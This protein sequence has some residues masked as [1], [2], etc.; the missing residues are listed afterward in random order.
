MDFYDLVRRR[1][2]CRAYRSEPVDEAALG[3][4][5]EAGRLAPTAANR[6]PFRVLVIPTGPR[7]DA[8]ARIYGRAWFGQA[9]L[10]LCVTGLAADAW[11]RK[12]GRN[13]VDVDVAIVM[14]HLT[15]A[16]TQEGLGT[17]WVANFDPSAARDVLGLEPR[18][19]PIVFTPLGRPADEPSPKARKPLSELVRRWPD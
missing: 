9:P 13:Y 18:E 4:I 11:V 8:L 14:D 7:R 6:Q 2:S 17:C 19:E 10:V 15:L 1:Y 3:R 16:A 5:L 12:D